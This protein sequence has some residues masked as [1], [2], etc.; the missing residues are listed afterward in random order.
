[1]ETLFEALLPLPD[2]V[3]LVV[4]T[5]KISSAHLPASLLNALPPEEWTELP[6]M[7]PVAVHRWIRF[8]DRAGRLNLRLTAGQTRPH[9]VRTI[10][11]AFYDISQGLPLHL[12]YS[13]EALARTGAELTPRDVTALPACPSGDIRSYY[14]SF[15]T[16]ADAKARTILHVLAGL[17]FGPPPFALHDCFGRCNQSLTSLSEINH[18][19]DYRETEV[20][21]FHGSLYAF[22]RDLPEHV[23]AFA[24]HASDVLAWLEACA[25]RYWRWAWLWITKAQL[26]NPSDLL[27]GPNREWAITSL[28]DGFPIEQLVSILDHAE[29]AALD[30]FDLPRLLALRL[31]KTRAMNG[32]EFQTDQW[33]LLQEVAL[34][35]SSDP[36]ALPNLQSRLHRASAEL[37]PFLVRTTDNSNRA[38]VSQSAIEELNGRIDRLLADETSSGERQAD[39]VDAIV[40]VAGTVRRP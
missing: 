21:P 22:V 30:A 12:I 7:S 8:Q 4:G 6:L 29:K 34:S 3:R 20:R 5:Q 24:T 19:L 18:L 16:R 11:G 27:A 1:M 10:A 13:F 15:W 40:A 35:L 36:Y 33:P 28:V 31:L 37:L 14:R 38:E 32:P 9:V 23:V 2:N 39:L 17:E 26:G 25:P